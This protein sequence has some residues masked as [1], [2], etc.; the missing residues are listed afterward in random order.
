[1]DRGGTSIDELMRQPN[2]SNISEDESMVQS[3]LEEINQ[4]KEQ[5][6]NMQQQQ[7][8]QN[9]QQQQMIENQKMME[10][11]MYE[12]KQQEMMMMKQR[13]QMMEK[14]R[15]MQQN[16]QN[17]QNQQIKTN[18]NNNNNN[19]DNNDNEKNMCENISL[20]DEFKSTI[21]FFSIFILINITQFNSLICGA[22][23]IENNNIFILLKGFIAT[24]I[25]FFVN[26]LVNKYI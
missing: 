5:Q 19:N 4:D 3:I 7:Q 25:F 24:V 23:S 21:I 8:Q 15:M 22:L 11:Q 18:N 10:K 13:Q 26:K 16:Q 6:I 9:M 17:Q 14:Q 20:L 2:N 1:M 12:K